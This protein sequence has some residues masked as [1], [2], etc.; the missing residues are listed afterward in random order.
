MAVAITKVQRGFQVFKGGRGIT[1]G[2]QGKKIPQ[3][4]SGRGSV[5]LVVDASG[6]YVGSLGRYPIEET[7][8]K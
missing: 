4:I 2:D 3:W 1:V 6:P 8:E 5:T 7:Q